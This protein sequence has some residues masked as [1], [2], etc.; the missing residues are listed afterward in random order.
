M[1][2]RSASSAAAK[3][4]ARGVRA[5]AAE[6]G[7]P[8]V[9]AEALEAGDHRVQPLAELA[10]EA[11]GLDRLDAGGA[12]ARV[13]AERHLPA[14][15]APRRHAHLLQGQR[16][17]PGGDVLAR[18]H[19]RVVLAGVVEERG[20][21]HPADE[22]VGL[23]GHGRDDDRDV[24]AALDL[25][26]DLGGGVADAV[27]VGDARCRRISSP[28]GAWLSL[29]RASFIG[30]PGGPQGAG[31]RR[32]R[33]HRPATARKMTRAQCVLLCCSSKG[34]GALRAPARNCKYAGKSTRGGGMGFVAVGSYCR[35]PGSLFRPARGEPGD[36]R[37]ASRGPRGELHPRC[38]RSER[39]GQGR[40]RRGRQGDRAL[41][42]SSARPSSRVARAAY[43]TGTRPSSPSSCSTGCCRRSRRSPSLLRRWWRL[44]LVDSAAHA[45]LLGE[46]DSGEGPG[47]GR[48]AGGR[49][50]G[51]RCARRRNGRIPSA[52][53][54]ARSGPSMRC[55]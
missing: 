41:P 37:A 29:G 31:P 21:P 18:R 43:R 47:A 45:E 4:T 50:P 55:G 30:R 16:H 51:E 14:L 44:K 22:L 7:D 1:S 20:L 32:H 12:V 17:Q 19:H 49:D 33:A 10:D 35:T 6:G 26:L 53:S 36:A 9:R 27:E 39:Q 38:R 23:A 8:P 5:A 28:D 24:V 3:A 11:L 13:G 46:W 40:A 15:P 54:S 52:G 34:E 42:R 48:C 25:A 2:Q